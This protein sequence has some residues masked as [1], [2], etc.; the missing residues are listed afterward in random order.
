MS[1]AVGVRPTGRL[2]AARRRRGGP[3]AP[4]ANRQYRLFSIA[5]LIS[6]TA[7]SVQSLTRVW[8]V[9]EQTHSPF[10][11]AVAAALTALPMLLFGF[12]GGA[13]SDRFDRRL[14]TIAVESAS[15]AGAA[16]LA[17]L[18]ATGSVTT[19]QIM[20]FSFV[21]GTAA[22]LSSPSKQT[23][24]ADLVPSRQQRGAIGLNMVVGNLAGIA[25]PAVGAFL[26]T[27]FGTSESMIA[28][29]AIAIVALPFYALV[30]GDAPRRRGRA[31]GRV[32][33]NLVK[34]V[35][36]VVADPALRW[37]LLV[38]VT[39]LITLSSRGAVYPSLVQDVLKGGAGA[40]GILEL[41][42]GLGAVAGPM[43]AVAV[44][45]R[46]P[47]RMV[48]VISG[49]SFAA[50]V[51]ALAFSPWFPLTALLAG[52]STFAGTIFF[53]TNMTAFQLSAP[54]EFRGR[55]VSVRFVSWGL[56]PVGTLTLGAL[57]E[58]AGPQFALLTFAAGG[59]LIFG[60]L[61]LLFRPSRVRAATAATAVSR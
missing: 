28:G 53:V 10:L 51:A 4:F 46:F 9:Q 17:F 3:F 19:W 6:G 24:L 32:L 56:Q 26:I 14:I 35:K 15:F 31:T 47:D 34:G 42:G 25:G 60:A 40:L 27:R 50:S 7:L 20:A 57:A 55:V 58:S 59:A 8:L 38:G 23:L 29:A 54:E 21:H 16:V 45:N 37:L 43:L 2:G 12:L 13:L 52:L 5:T 11:V 18:V 49:F 1:L 61:V 33:K 44:F 30:R 41:V 48:E 39:L 36:F 22:A